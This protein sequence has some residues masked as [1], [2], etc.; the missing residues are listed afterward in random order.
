MIAVTGNLELYGKVPKT[1]QTR[2][3]IFAE[4]GVSKI[5]VKEAS[6]WKIGD[7]IIIGPSFT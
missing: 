5:V 4:K 6:D 1:T 2:L 3:K 7:E